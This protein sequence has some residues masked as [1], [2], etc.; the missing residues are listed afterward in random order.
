MPKIQKKDFS[1][2]SEENPALAY[3]TTKE[4]VNLSN[5]KNIE[6]KNDGVQYMAISLKI[7]VELYQFARSQGYKTETSMTAYII[8]VLKE[9]M[10][11][12]NKN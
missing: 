12:K 5:N 7:P 9:D 6:R 11:S 2:I 3:I 10:E 4:G 8:K 1:K